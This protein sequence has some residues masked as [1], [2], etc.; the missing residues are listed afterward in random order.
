LTKKHITAG[1]AM[2]VASFLLT[3]CRVSSG[4]LYGT[5]SAWL[6]PIIWIPCAVLIWIVLKGVQFNKSTLTKVAIAIIG[7][8]II[9]A[10]VLYLLQ[11]A[12]I[13]VAIIVIVAVV[14]KHRNK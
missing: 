5:I 2:L 4:R 6:Y 12:I 13:V 8:L 10:L 7:G 1:L 9:G 11:V 14:T 3:A